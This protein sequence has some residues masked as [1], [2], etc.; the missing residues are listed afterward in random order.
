MTGMH[1]LTDPGMFE[2][3][4]NA[5]TSERQGYTP[6]YFLL[7]KGL[8]DPAGGISWKQLEGR[9]T[10]EQAIR[11]MRAGHNIGI[12]ATGMDA[13][14]IVDVDDIGA[15]PD[16]IV[17]PTLSTRS[18]KRIGRHYFYFTDDPRCKENLPT[19]GKGEIRSRFEYVVAPGSFVICDRKTTDAMPESQRAQAGRYTVENERAPDT[20]VFEELPPVFLEQ[21]KRNRE[22]ETEAKKR[23]K[24]KVEAR[25]GE[26][27]MQRGEKNKSALW[28]LSIDDVMSIPN[29]ARFT[30][31]FH[32]STT[33]K[34]TALNDNGGLTCWRHLV[35]HTALSALAVLAGVTDCNSAGKGINNGHPSCIDWTDGE[36]LWKMWVFA[37]QE[38]MIPKDDPIPLAAVKT[39]Y[40][41][42]NGICKSEEIEDGWKLP[43]K[44]YRQTM[45]ALEGREKPITKTPP[46]PKP[47]VGGGALAAMGDALD[48]KLDSIDVAE[49]IQKTNPII[50]DKTKQF[51]IWDAVKTVWLM[52]DEVDVFNTL[53]RVA[54]LRGGVV[55]SSRSTYLQA[56]KLTGRELEVKE[57]EDNW[58]AFAD[59]VIDVETDKRFKAT[60]E[61][62]F[63]NTI[64][65]KYGDSTETPTIDRLF[66]EW[67]GAEWV[68]LLH[69]I[70][71][72][73]LFNRY[74]IHR[75]FLLFGSGRNGKGQFLTLVQRFL[76]QDNTA[77]TDFNRLIESR[78]EAAKLYHKKAAVMGETEF[79]EMDRTS[80]FK[81]LTGEDMIPGERKYGAP[82]D[83][84]NHAKLLIGS[85]SI[86]PSNDKSEGY[87][88]RWIIIDFP[89]KFE[90]S[91]PVIDT[92]PEWEYQNLC[93][94]AVEKLR[95]LL[96]RGA[97]YK[98]GDTTNRAQR[99]EKKSN[100]IQMF[101]DATCDMGNELSVPLWE[102][103][104]AYDVYQGEKRL[105]KLT[106]KA[107]RKWL[108]DRGFEIVQENVTN[109][110]GRH[111]W[112]I[113]YGVEFGL[114]AK[115]AKHA[116]SEQLYTR[117]KPVGSAHVSHV[118]HVE[119][120]GECGKPLS[121][122]TFLGKLGQGK[123]CAICQE[124]RD[125]SSKDGMQHTNG[126][127]DPSKN[128]THLKNV[129]H[130]NNGRS[131]IGSE[132]GA[133]MDIR[134]A[135]YKL[136][137]VRSIHEF[138]P[139]QILMEMPKGTGATT[140]AIEAQLKDQATDLKIERTDNGKWR[141][142]RS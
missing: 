86:P 36:T 134:S 24:A 133:S 13:L 5:L 1:H 69:E 92:I 107:I 58:I 127:E 78:F 49:A 111:T 17:K 139:A 108:V 29:R 55:G 35:T 105:R 109:D 84:I 27:P 103:V 129:A 123:I 74:P 90:V 141:Q 25:R 26:K 50:Y 117:E 101:I 56:I 115:H 120:C 61:Y 16:E 8:K 99:Y 10:F 44:A 57:P 131:E 21:A 72:Y 81:Q 79:K 70:V 73:C 130:L 48:K 94:K 37:K 43:A 30:S 77:A 136:G 64:P 85:N 2:R 102:F 122:E 11:K 68:E 121:G 93:R 98:E 88:S 19:E 119:F 23:R 137:Y 113:I 9:L 63:T 20:I 4:N 7:S 128:E 41:V 66:V 53:R 71:G 42:K 59:C 65:H 106:K 83:Y 142:I 132:V 112:A 110:T 125:I 76:G 89:N 118:S 60:K 126:S 6:W 32:E 45:A 116:Y 14:C 75:A 51:W 100:P 140:E 22:A 33:G 80:L 67:V 62:M 95:G 87:G 15:T 34:N 12:A 3:F 31:L 18:R 104:E 114:H 39:W 54:G 96:E 138:T 124:K 82:F 52:V 46:A 28:D 40:A 38:G 47:V 135:I 91:K 97:F